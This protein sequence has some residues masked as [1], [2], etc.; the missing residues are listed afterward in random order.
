M[1]DVGIY[2]AI[3]SYNP[4]RAYYFDNLLLRF[5]SVEFEEDLSRAHRDS[6][7]VADDYLPPW[8]VPS[9]RQYY[10]MGMSTVNVLRGYF[11][12]LGKYCQD[13]VLFA[14]VLMLFTV[15]TSWE[16]AISSDGFE[17]MNTAESGQCAA[18]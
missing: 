3:T 14:D 12:S 17:M 6:Y 4:L 5:C 1:W 11:V 8:G 13:N 18:I 9:L 15:A 16:F 7:V 10:R 2:V